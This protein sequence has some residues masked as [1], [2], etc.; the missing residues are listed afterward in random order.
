MDKFKVDFIG[1]GAEKAATYWVAA[2]LRDHPEI[3]FSSSKEIA[4]FNECDQHFLKVKNPRYKRGIA[5]Y[6]RYFEH[7]DPKSIKGEYTPT[8]LY[9]KV[10]AKRI[11]SNFPHVKLI[12]C[13]RDPTKRA[14][15]Q[16]LHDISTG[17]IKDIGFEKAVKKY[18]SYVKKGLYYRYLKYYLEVFPKDQVFIFLVD[19]I[20]KN[21]RKVVRDLY[22]FLKLKNT[23][24]VPKSLNSK[25]NKASI[26]RSSSLNYFL[27][28]VEYFLMKNGLEPIHKMLED[29]GIRKK[30]FFLSYYNNRKVINPI[31]YP[32]M[33]PKTE[34]FL[35]SKFKKDI[36]NLEKLLKR[37]LSNWKV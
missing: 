22:K 19:D 32:E 6:K 25:P 5:W 30:L 1:I 21:K 36:I 10:T 8:Y 27:M 13:L 34:K 9:S 31:D 12:V 20:K 33:S 26:S 3:C 2:V 35:K 14:L 24:F 28:Q 17:V 4:F 29:F 11:K 15:S 7:C 37:D 18:D 23:S 16:Y